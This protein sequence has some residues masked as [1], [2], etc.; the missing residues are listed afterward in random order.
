MTDNTTPS[1]ETRFP[2][3]IFPLLSEEHRRDVVARALQHREDCATEGVRKRLNAS[4]RRLHLDGFRDPSR[5]PHQ[6]LL[7]PVLDAI[8]R[9][10]HL[11]AHAVLNAWMKSREALREAVTAHLNS[12][13]IPVPEP[14]DACFES[15]WPF[16][17]WWRERTAMTGN[18]DSPG[19]EAAELMLC[20][21]SRRFPAPPP[22]ESPL[23]YGWIEELLD[24]SPDAPEWV[25]ADAFTNWVHDIRRA[26]HREMFI[27]CK[28]AIAL[29]CE[30]LRQQFD[31]DL[32]YLDIDPD[33]WPSE[34]ENRPAFA[35]PTLQFVSTLRDQLE[36]YHPVR[37][38][39]PSRDEELQRSVERRECEDRILRLV[40]D[41]QERKAQ[42]EPPDEPVPEADDSGGQRVADD[43]PGMVDENQQAAFSALKAEHDRVQ[44]DVAL[45]R[46]ESDRLREE[47]RGLQSEKTQRDQ[48]IDRLRAELSGSR[49]T[50]E[51]WRRTYVDERRRSRT[52]GDDGSFTVDSV[53]GA[54]TLAGKTFP[55]RLL[56]K[57]N[58]KSGQDTP[59][60]SPGEV[61]DVLAWLAT[62]YR[63][64]PPD[65]I[66]EACPGW[67][68]K[69]NQS[70]PT[71][72][73]FRDWYQTRVD[74]TTW[75]LS[76]HI[77]KGKSHDPRH[78]IRI[79]FAWDETNDRVIVGFVGPHQRNRQS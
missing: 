5:A 56:I 28:D 45:L 79:A 53:R 41:W 23:L 51:Q 48:E 2:D 39:A 32:R 67:F 52:E 69:P 47:N 76:N 20:L 57:L 54:I 43:G 11:L 1:H 18:E 26:K 6:R 13:G 73:R 38:Q 7:R 34:V 65:Q 37:L 70:E 15:F 74:G 21:I 29:G 66:G 40:T 46:E 55:E 50:E 68:Y 36:A 72:G 63:N 49:R 16:D 77:G 24:L 30:N 22:L 59:F 75:E 44:Q 42:P 64:T 17:E 31:E 33:P 27:W 12:R 3:E 61:F 35:G 4:L 25:E 8:E 9:G 58:S 19:N 14:P 60:E 71:M 62:A 10:D 78:T